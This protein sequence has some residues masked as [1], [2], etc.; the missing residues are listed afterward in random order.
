LIDLHCATSRERQPALSSL[1]DEFNGAMGLV[2][3]FP[4]PLCEKKGAAR[5]CFLTLVGADTAG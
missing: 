2:A 5:T 3:T 1:T 4:V